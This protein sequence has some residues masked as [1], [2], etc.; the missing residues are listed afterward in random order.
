MVNAVS[1]NASSQSSNVQSS[2]KAS[3]VRQAEEE[4]RRQRAQEKQPSTQEASKVSLGQQGPSASVAPTQSPG[5]M[6]AAVAK[7]K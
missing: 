1:G 7:I 4:K 2:Q 6:Y 3:D 5:Q